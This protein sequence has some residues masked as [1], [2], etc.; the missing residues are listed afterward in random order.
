MMNLLLLLLLMSMNLDV[1]VAKCVIESSDYTSVAFV[2]KSDCMNTTALLGTSAEDLRIEFIAAPLATN[3]FN[4]TIGNCTVQSSVQPENGTNVWT[5]NNVQ[6]NNGSNPLVLLLNG[7]ENS[8]FYDDYMIACEDVIMLEDFKKENWKKLS[9]N[10]AMNQV[11]N[12]FQMRF[13]A[14]KCGEKNCF[15]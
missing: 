14:P 4:F 11:I 12:G 7:K 1:T 10:V 13:V 2:F 15:G 6:Y 8:L 9:V 3:S 5:F